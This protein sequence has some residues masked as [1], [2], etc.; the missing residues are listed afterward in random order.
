MPGGGY[1][2]LAP[3]DSYRT[4]HKI[5][6]LAFALALTAGACLAQEWQFPS[7]RI[8]PEEI[9]QDSIQLVQFT[10]NS[11]AVKW[12]YTG[13]GA[14]NMLAFTERHTG[15]TVRTEIG[16]YV[17]VG[18]IAPFTSLPGCASYADWRTGWLAHRTDKMFCASEADAKKIVAGLKK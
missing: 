1:R 10:T 12:T 18:S 14:T 15:E 3:K 13:A 2:R 16:D 5:H 6:T 4:M 8:L 17:S 9:I 11:F 7:R